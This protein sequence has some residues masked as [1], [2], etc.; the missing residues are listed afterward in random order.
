MSS[1]VILNSDNDDRRHLRA[2][3]RDEDTR[4]A[5]DQVITDLMLSNA[6]VQRGGIKDAVRE[7]GCHRSPRILLVDITDAD[8]PLSAVNELA[9]VCEPGVAVIAIGD[10]NDVG[11]FRELVSHGVTD[12][13][14]KPITVSLLQKSLSLL[15]DNAGSSRQTSRLGRLIAVTGTRGGV[16]STLAACNIAWCI[17]QRRKRRVALVDLDLQFGNAALTLDLEPS[18][19]LRDALEHSNRIDALFIDRSMVKKSDTLFVLSGEE[20]LSET[21]LIDYTSIDIMLRELRSKFHFV[22]VDLP[23]QINPCTQHILQSA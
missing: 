11:L 10:R 15:T 6:T 9:E 8:L 7:L 22:I 4:K 1:P 5:V 13:L 17:A 23:R 19:G 18:H 12:Y 21:I 2:F 14:V 16:G 20:S 3:V